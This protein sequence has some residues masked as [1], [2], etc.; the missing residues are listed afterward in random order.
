MIFIVAAFSVCY[1]IVESIFLYLCPFFRTILHWSQCNLCLLVCFLKVMSVYADFMTD[2]QICFA[3]IIILWIFFV[4]KIQLY[5][6]FYFII[7]NL[8][9]HHYRIPAISCF[10][11]NYQGTAFYQVPLLTFL[12]SIFW[13]FTDWI[14][15][16]SL[17]LKFN[18]VMIVFSILKP[19]YF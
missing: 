4:L 10:L 5:Y 13:E 9:C 18:F 8:H 19:L 2:R 12:F 6:L 16:Q 1:G 14:E 15:L 3:T 17:F 11:Y 7:F